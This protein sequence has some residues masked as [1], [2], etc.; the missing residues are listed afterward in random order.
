MKTQ[1]CPNCHVA[2]DVTV[3]VSGQRVRCT[4]CGIHF[5]VRRSD[6]SMIAQ[7]IASGA[8]TAVPHG[9]AAVHPGVAVDVEATQLRMIQ[10]GA[11]SEANAASR[12]PDE[13][14]GYELLEVLGR[15]GMGE[16]WRA[17]QK[18]LGR[19][20]AIKLLPERLSRNPEFI[21]RFQKEATALASLSHP[22]IIQIIDRGMAD[23]QYF[24]VMEYVQGRSLRELMSAGR[25]PAR[26]ALRY[27]YQIC[28]AIDYAHE[29]HIIHRDL[30][31]ENI[32]VD[33]HGNVKVAD[34]GLAGIQVGA[35]D[36]HLTATAVA[37]GTVNYMAPEQRR[38]AKNVDGRA[39]LYSLGVIF[40]EMLTGELPIGRF[41]LPSQRVEGLDARLD[42]IVVQT[43]DPD[44]AS[45]PDRASQINEHILPLLS[46]LYGSGVKPPSHPAL[47]ASQASGAG[48]DVATVPLQGHR[49]GWA[50]GAGVLAV[51]GGIL[52]FMRAT[53]RE[54]HVEHT[55]D[56]TA[57]LFHHHGD[58]HGHAGPNTLPANTDG[59]LLAQ[60][61]WTE[62]KQGVKL[63]LRFAPPATG[64][65]PEVIH[66]HAGSWDLDDGKL[67]ATQ[68]GEVTS[69]GILIP[70]AYVDDRFFSSDEF[71]AEVR[72]QVKP[73]ERDFPVRPDAA[74]FAELAFRLDDAQ[75]SVFADP[76]TGM[77]LTWRYQ[78]GDREV[79]GST[80]RDLRLHV[81]DEIYVPDTG[82][83]VVRLALRRDADGD[84]T[85]VEAFLNGQRFAHKSLVGLRHK[86][87]KVALGCRNL[88]CSFDELTVRGAPLTTA[89][90]SAVQGSAER[91]HQGEK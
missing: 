50:I 71:G 3:F 6:A 64:A 27:I 26:E 45:R 66:A 13:L 87:G 51:L 5:E 39:D 2:V 52:F 17:Q 12:L 40:Y 1:G 10:G 35:A 9:G 53:G 81:A 29:Q 55:E 62:S 88:H 67:E 7:R 16:V 78:V 11:P 72:M 47:P 57:L 48:S 22:N 89:E 21:A 80:E 46:E 68:A 58:A 38:D 91:V 4:G 73:L 49:R 15:G 56:G 59:E 20:V 34:F 18:S 33:D 43:L 31:P 36:Q 82:S 86:V 19:T 44:P 90:R 41:K 24:F 77:R 32:L 42:P 75:V 30:K 37:M 14:P 70:R 23:G 28:R 54:V 25:M 61:T 83:F 69:D 79:T 74:S 84:A 85:D 65:A 8:P 60:S 76:K 63:Q